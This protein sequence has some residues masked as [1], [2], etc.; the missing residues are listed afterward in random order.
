[1]NQKLLHLTLDTQRPLSLCGCFPVHR[2]LDSKR[3]GLLDVEQQET[4]A[5]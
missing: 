4:C 3:T 1:M 5:L 2:C